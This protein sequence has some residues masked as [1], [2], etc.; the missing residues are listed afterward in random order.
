MT[1]AFASGVLHCAKGTAHQRPHKPLKRPARAEH[2]PGLLR[3]LWPFLARLKGI[4]GGRLPPKITR[5]RAREP[6]G[7]P[8]FTANREKRRGRPRGADLALALT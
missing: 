6:H 7:P 4:P 2:H 3:L 5:N 8:S 1:I